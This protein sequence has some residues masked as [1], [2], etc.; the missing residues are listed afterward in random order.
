[1]TNQDFGASAGASLSD[2]NSTQK[3]G[4]Q[5]LGAVAQSMQNALPPPTAS[6][7]PTAFGFNTIGTVTVSV[8][9]SSSIRHGLIFHNPGATAVYVYLSAMSPVPTTAALG[10]SIQI[11]AG[12]TVML[13]STLYPNLNAA[14]SGFALV[15]SCTLT[16][17]EFH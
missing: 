2:L 10:G 1:M 17:V 8:L 7:S 6:T 14:W 11:A 16:V 15:N 9:G 5:N 12:S 4:V 3:G 13:P